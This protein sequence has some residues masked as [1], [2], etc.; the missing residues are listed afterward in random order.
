MRICVDATAKVVQGDFPKKEFFER[1][2]GAH[3]R[4]EWEEG[5]KGDQDTPRLSF[6]FRGTDERDG[7]GS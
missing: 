6:Q 7:N 1:E 4:N 3:G 5:E 2:K